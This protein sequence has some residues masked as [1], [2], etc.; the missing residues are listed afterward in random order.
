MKTKIKE[1]TALVL[2]VFGFMVLPVSADDPLD[3]YPT[4]LGAQWGQRYYA[5][6]SARTIVAI[7]EGY[8]VAGTQTGSVGPGIDTWATLVRFDLNGNVAATKTFHEEDDHNAAFDIIASYDAEARIDGYIV[9][10]TRHQ[11]YPDGEEG[12]YWYNPW[13]WLMKTNT[14]FE[15][16][17]ERTFGDPESD[18]GY[19]AFHDGS[20]FIVS[21]MYSNPNES[22][23]LL[24]TDDAGN[25]M[26]RIYHMSPWFLAPVVYSSAPAIDGGLVL[27][28]SRG[29]KKLSPY[30]ADTPP[31]EPDEDD[32]TVATSD[33]FY[34]VI[35]VTGGYVA[36]GHTEIDAPTGHYDLVLIKVDTGGDVLWRHTFGRSPQALGA[37]GMNDFGREVIQTA[38]GGLAVIGSTESY[39]WHGASDMW[40]IKTDAS[41][42]VQWDVVMGD[43]AGD[44]GYG[45][46]Q[47]GDGAL[48]AAGTTTYGD[49]SWMYVVKLPGDF[50]PPTPVFTYDPESPFYVQETVQFDASG[51]TPGSAGDTIVL[52]EWDF[53]DGSSASGMIV[54]HVYIRPGIYSVTLYVTDSN[55]VRRE[56]SQTVE[57]L[58]LGMIW[59]RTFGNGND[60]FHDL[61]EGDGDNFLLCGINCYSSSSC[62]VWAAK[63]DSAGNTV[64]INVYPDSYYGGR[65]GARAGILGHDD[66]YIIAGFRDKGITG[67]T[68]DVRILKLNSS[69]G[70]KMWDTF[71]DMGAYDEA[72]D[73][74]RVPS[75]GYIVVGGS[76]DPSGS[77]TRVW[78]IK[79]DENG[80]QEW[81]QTFSGTGDTHLQGIA[82][83]PTDD[84][85]YLMVCSKYS[86][87]SDQPII[88]IKADGAGVEEWRRAMPNAD[89]ARSLGTWVH[90][91]IDGN[92]KIAGTFNS[93]YALIA[94]DADGTSHDAVT[95][96]TEYRR[97]FIDD[98]DVAPDGGY[99]MVGTHYSIAN[100]DDVYVAR[101]D[102]Q[103]N[104]AW[105]FTMGEPD[106]GGENGSSIAYL[107][108]GSVVVL[109]SDYYDKV[110]RLTKFGPL[111][112]TKGDIS[113]DGSVNV[114]DAVLGL[115]I[116][117][118]LPPGLPVNQRAIMDASDA[119][120]LQL[121]IFVFQRASGV[122]PSD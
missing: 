113:G 120:D 44:R 105:F 77:G 34:S 26:W 103:G 56:T 35:P 121:L 71:Y 114:A 79:I 119:F 112:S 33:T 43:A 110:S 111:P 97:D 66:N 45:I 108:D 22:G 89:G 118:G 102:S 87:V 50:I 55:G 24:R 14:A 30:A 76:A 96:G 7:P 84:G 85:G 80:D 41:G 23:Y 72:F 27:A 86:S 6:T 94:L 78:L 37:T 106:V 46:V 92:F 67:E 59:E 49:S 75:G 20:G 88:A 100:D 70:T 104:V 42:A 13:I 93:D 57:A 5:E 74:K 68:R 58:G 61:T 48:V 19:A 81:A 109:S 25:L 73:V 83:T 116:L 99:V 95:W 52:Y 36:T 38:D 12:P 11:P 21:G 4:P 10:G 65:D 60:F 51:S 32:W 15:K 64:W 115:Q 16:Q 1:L 9:T 117:A 31:P 29:L 53:G 69:D 40:L 54:D 3:D 39:G 63:A 107:P 101:T 98:A 17:W 8:V 90:Q 122:R 62:Y 47:D 91:D 28:T 2:L 18:Y 82:V